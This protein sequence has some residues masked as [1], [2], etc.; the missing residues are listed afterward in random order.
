MIHEV[1]YKLQTEKR[2][3]TYFFLCFGPLSGSILAARKTSLRESLTLRYY[4]RLAHLWGRWGDNSLCREAPCLGEDVVLLGE[5]LQHAIQVSGQK[6]LS[7]D[8]VHPWEVVDFLS[9]NTTQ[10]SWLVVVL[11]TQTTRLKEIT[12]CLKLYKSDNKNKPCTHAKRKDQ[13]KY[14]DGMSVMIKMQK[15]KHKKPMMHDPPKQ[16]NNSPKEHKKPMMHDPPKQ[17]N[18]NPKNPD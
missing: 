5:H 11:I 8:L 12:F 16:T 2:Q 10:R 4:T 18:N 14:S 17:T 7:A 9:T 13:A 15:N 3:Q 1:I 6:I